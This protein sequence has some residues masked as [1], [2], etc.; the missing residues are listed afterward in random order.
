MRRKGSGYFIGELCPRCLRLVR[1]QK[2]GECATPSCMEA[3]QR[4]L[5]AAAWEAEWRNGPT[6]ES[7]PYRE[8]DTSESR[9]P[10]LNPQGQDAGGPDN[11][12]RSPGR[13]G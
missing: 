8:C 7:R 1:S 12:E 6:G 13:R 3:A 10:F 5:R 9:M 4:A 2:T 11:A